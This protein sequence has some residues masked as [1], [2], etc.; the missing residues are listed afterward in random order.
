M[1][2][3]PNTSLVLT[4]D[5]L[6]YIRRRFNGSPSAAVHATLGQAAQLKHADV[7]IHPG[8][9]Q[10]WAL[11]SNMHPTDLDFLA[12]AVAL[13]RLHIAAAEVSRLGFGIRL[14]MLGDDAANFAHFRYALVYSP[15][16]EDL[17]EW[18]D[19]GELELLRDI[20][21]N[22]SPA[23]AFERWRERITPLGDIP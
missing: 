18:A 16:G 2:T 20:A 6:A 9:R 17:S 13:R 22:L 12:D 5:E 21:R 15:T 3:N 7:Y 4:Q 1:G 10:F 19:V 11:V 23:E 14:A 8:Y